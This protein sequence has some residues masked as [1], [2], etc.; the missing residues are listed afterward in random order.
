MSFVVDG[1][2]G[3][4]A[5]IIVTWA[6]TESM[7]KWDPVAL[8]IGLAAGYYWIGGLPNQ[9]QDMMLLAQG[10][11]VGGGAVYAYLVASNKAQ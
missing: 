7:V 9:G 5:S 3:P 11:L 10:Y 8:A 4:K 2:T 1:S 6:Y